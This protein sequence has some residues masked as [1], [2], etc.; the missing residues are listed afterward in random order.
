MKTRIISILLAVCL[1][2]G[3]LPVGVLAANPTSGSCGANARWEYDAATKTLSISGSG[4]MTDYET[5]PVMGIENTPPWD[6]YRE[7]IEHVII[8]EGITSIGAEAFGCE[9]SDKIYSNLSSASIAPTVKK[10]GDAAFEGAE[11]LKSIELQ[12]VTS[13]G[14][15]A[16]AYTGLESI[17]IPASVEAITEDG[18]DFEWASCFRG[19][20]NLQSITVASGNPKYRSVDGVLFAENALLCYPA[21]KADASYVVPSGTT[22]IAGEAFRDNSNITA[23]SVP[24]SVQ[25]IGNYAFLFCDNLVNVDLAEGIREVASTAFAYPAVPTLV[26]PASVTDFTSDYYRTELV[27]TAQTLYFTGKTAPTFDTWGC[28]TNTVVYY[29]ENATGWD[30]VQQQDNVKHYIEQGWLKFKTGTPPTEPSEPTDELKLV[31]TSPANGATDVTEDDSLVLTFNQ[32]LSKNL[33]WT[34][35]SIYIK[36]YNTDETALKIDSAKFY[37]LGGTVNGNSLTVPLVF[38]SLE[39]GKY[40]ITMDAGVIVSSDGTMLFAGIQ[41]KQ[42]LSFEFQKESHLYG[43]D[44]TMGRDSLSFGNYSDKGLK[45]EDEHMSSLLKKLSVRDKLL[46]LKTLGWM[47]LHSNPK[48]FGMS[49]VMELMYKQ[50][51][52]PDSFGA[53]TTFEIKK[54]N[55][56]PLISYCHMLQVLSPF[57]SVDIEDSRKT[58]SQLAMK[59]IDA[60]VFGDAPILVNTKYTKGLIKEEHT[61]LAYGLDRDSDKDNYIVHVADPNNLVYPR[62]DS[63]TNELIRPFIYDSY[64]SAKLYIDKD[65]LQITKYVVW[66]SYPEGVFQNDIFPDAPF[67]ITSVYLNS[68]TVQLANLLPSAKA[69]LQ[70]PSI[71]YSTLVTTG[72]SFVINA[73]SGKTATI[74]ANSATGNL[75]II[76]PLYIS[77][78]ET[79]DFATY[80]IESADGYK[81]TYPDAENHDT[82]LVFPENSDSG[83]SISSTAKTV[84]FH[85]NGYVAFSEATG[86][87]SLTLLSNN[88]DSTLYMLGAQTGNSDASIT[89]VG[90]QYK[91]H[92][93][94]DFTDTIVYGKNDWCTAKI[95]TLPVRNDIYIKEVKESNNRK[96]VLLNEDGS[97]VSSVSIPLY[98]CFFSNGGSFVDAVTNIPYN[99][100]LQQPEAPTK[101]GYRFAGWYKDEALTQQWRFDRDGRHGALRKMGQAGAD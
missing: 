79:P 51:I 28:T 6:A 7:E 19:C 17:Y 38:S 64:E 34:K 35:G 47:Q 57:K 9:K 61:V 10:I 54:D 15:R 23:V 1:I 41:S 73:S 63:V 60:I 84:E 50:Y 52:H 81:I 99:S 100:K 43:C 24:A 56:K 26:L 59:I 85:N 78:G 90:E 30:D 93:S 95:D 5:D 69:A 25:K 11:K 96:L 44:F 82:L 27:G 32:E 88:S 46:L 71:T 70:S 75:D 3:L 91:L 20:I 92:S 29:P 39:A 77:S 101:T 49:A 40:Y 37:A 45:I 16:L 65:S 62:R 72:A 4:D 31:S 89:A 67:K 12:S 97:K 68:E 74:S 18:T 76:G 58:Q 13:I 36:N 94:S 80:Y 22:R 87:S 66:Q 98:V 42:T 2:F 48:C 86:T 14:R 8:N 83:G 55:L 33:N 21:G 53:K